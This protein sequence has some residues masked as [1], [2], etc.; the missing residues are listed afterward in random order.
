MS[1][2]LPRRRPRR[3]L[4][5]LTAALGV[6]VL[7]AGCGGTSGAAT[8]EAAA[9]GDLVELVL[10][11][12]ATSANGLANTP[13]GVIGYALADDRAQDVLAEYGFHYQEFAAFEN[14]PPAARPSAPVRSNWPRSATLTRSSPARP[15]S[16][17]GR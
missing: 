16:R 13:Q 10:G 12:P 7:L 11:A 15:A 8:N 17:T 9:E 1:T 5:S 3:R 2:S 14:G 6:A 4:L